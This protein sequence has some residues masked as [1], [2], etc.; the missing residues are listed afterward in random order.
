MTQDEIYLVAGMAGA[1]VLIVVIDLIVSLVRH[2]RL[3][4]A[5]LLKSRL[6]LTPKDEK[7]VAAKSEWIRRRLTAIENASNGTPRGE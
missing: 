1:A 3:A 7:A 5:R 4:R 2:R 6:E